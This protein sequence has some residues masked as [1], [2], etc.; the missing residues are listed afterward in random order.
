MHAWVGRHGGNVSALA[1]QLGVGRSTLQS[2]KV[3]RNFGF[4]E[5]QYLLYVDARSAKDEME[6]EALEHA[7]HG[8]AAA[9]CG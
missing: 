2:W 5:P 1:R 4:G 6:D 7:H 9:N 8:G 3:D